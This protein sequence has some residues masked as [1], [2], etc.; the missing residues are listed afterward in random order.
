EECAELVADM[1]ARLGGLSADM[2][3]TEEL[4]AIFR[5]VHSIKAGAGAFGRT[6]LVTFAHRFE[7]VLDLLRDGKLIQDDRVTGILV[8]S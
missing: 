3:N 1:E 7:A 5:A 2:G 6:R 4:N 8:R